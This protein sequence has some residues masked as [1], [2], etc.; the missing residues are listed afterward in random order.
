MPPLVDLVVVKSHEGALRVGSEAT[1]VIEVSNAGPTDDPGPITLTDTLPVGLRYVAATGDGW[2]CTAAGAAITCTLADGLAVGDSTTIRV[3]V[4]VL[5]AAYP[6]VDNTAAVSTPSEDFDSSN[7]TDPPTAARSGR[8][9]TSRC[10][11]RLSEADNDRATWTIRVV[12]R[13]PNAADLPFTVVDDLPEG[14]AYIAARGPGWTCANAGKHITCTHIEPL[15]VGDSST[16]TVVSRITAV[17]GTTV[18]NNAVV[19]SEQDSNATNNRDAAAL[20][21]TAG[22][23]RGDQSRGSDGLPRTGADVARLLALSVLL[24]LAG[25]GA[26]RFGRRR[27]TQV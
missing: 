17:A 26:I 12:S 27:E 8:S 16:I 2:S 20:H 24:M 18:T 11:K 25:A 6:S 1:Y 3:H 7:N 5:P 21:V 23:L 19:A 4:D 9:S 14:L 10:T 15:A 22:I 13:G